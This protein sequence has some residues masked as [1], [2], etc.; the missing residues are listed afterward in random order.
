MPRC[1][2]APAAAQIVPMT[3]PPLTPRSRAWL[4]AFGAP[5]PESRPPFGIG[6]NQGPPL[7]GLGAVQ[8][9]RRAKAAAWKAPV[10]VVRRRIRGAEAVGLTYHEY[11]LEIIERGVWLVPGRDDARIARIVAARAA[12]EG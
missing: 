12:R 4:A 11:T 7:A 5:A 6:H 9:W 2:G 10:E 3:P 1:A 8:H